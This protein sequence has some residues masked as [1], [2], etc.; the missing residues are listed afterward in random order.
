[1][2]G[3]P[4][5]KGRVARSV[6]AWIVTGPPGHL[7]GGLADWAQLMA[8][9]WLTRRQQRSGG[10]LFTYRKRGMQNSVRQSDD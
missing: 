1:M 2:G 8:G 5:Y 7:A 9:H 6:L 4:R 10:R 3:R